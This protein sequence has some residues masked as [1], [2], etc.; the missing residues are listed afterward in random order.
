MSLTEAWRHTAPEHV[1]NRIQLS[2]QM[3]Q[4]AVCCVED[5][6]DNLSGLYAYLSASYAF[7][8]RP[9]LREDV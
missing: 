2:Q 9:D 3:A 1:E 8:A 4:Y 5:G 6:L 7:D